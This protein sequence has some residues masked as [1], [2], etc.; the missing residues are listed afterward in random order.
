MPT[1][2]DLAC[3]KCTLP[4]CDEKSDRCLFR[5]LNPS[6]TERRRDYFQK[7]YEQNK[8]RM[9]AR[10]SAYAKAKQ[11]WKKI[12][13]RQYFKDRYKRKCDQARVNGESENST[14]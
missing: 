4:F 13:R 9:N 14:N 1:G 10:T 3:L 12:D 11:P 5:I 2:R 8:D 7:Y 6:E